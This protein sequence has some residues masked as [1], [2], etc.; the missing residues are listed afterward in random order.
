MCTNFEIPFNLLIFPQ[1]FYWALINLLTL[2]IFLLSMFEILARI[3]GF[4]NSMRQ[5]LKGSDGKLR[6]D[7]KWV[8]SVAEVFQDEIIA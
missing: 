7:R 5:K 4:E 3:F 8:Q 1:I 2:L 6:G